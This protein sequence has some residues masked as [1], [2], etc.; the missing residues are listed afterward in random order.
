MNRHSCNSRG[1]LSPL[2][3]PIP[4]PGLNRHHLLSI[5]F[6]SLKWSGKRGSN[7]RPRPWQGRALPLSYS[8]IYLK[9]RDYIKFFFKCKDFCQEMLSFYMKKI[10]LLLFITLLPLLGENSLISKLD[11]FRGECCNWYYKTLQNIDAY[12][13]KTSQSE[14][15]TILE[16]NSI[17]IVLSNRYSTI[18][19][20]K[21][22]IYF[23]TNITLPNINKRLE[24]SIN[25]Q[26]RR[27]YQNRSFST[28]ENQ[29][30]RDQDLHF[31]LGYRFF[32]KNDL[33]LKLKVATHIAKPH[34]IYLRLSTSKDVDF[35]KGSALFESRIY[36]YLFQNRLIVS[37]SMNFTRYLSPHFRLFFDNSL[38]WKNEDINWEYD[39]SLELIQKVSTRDILNY[40]LSY[41]A[42]N[43]KG[44]YTRK[45]NSLKFGLKHFFR[46]WLYIEPSIRFLHSR[47]HDFANE[48]V[49]RFD[50]GFVVSRY[51]R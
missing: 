31:G 3:L 39:H 27:S 7:S 26:N 10:A 50:I 49:Y 41:G 5:K 9:R 29:N 4:P 32:K 25:R 51:R 14:Y 24:M 44:L 17:K 12:F 22:Y 33:T 43:L 45:Y 34:H 35:E 36:K 38:N 21:P 8:R 23:K 46:E 42:D 40:D 16:K 1:I 19:K 18:E 37:N 20:Y 28:N 2:C 30:L 13:G 48:R 47:E 15:Q 11:R 6:H